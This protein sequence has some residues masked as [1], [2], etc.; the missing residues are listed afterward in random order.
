MIPS[1]V[2]AAF[3]LMPS[4]T[5]PVL[6]GDYLPLETGRQWHYRDEA[7]NQLTLTVLGT[8]I[9]ADRQT[10]ILQYEELN[11]RCYN[12]FLSW[13]DQGRLLLHARE[14]I[15][16]QVVVF[17]PPLIYLAPEVAGDVTG[18]T[19][20]YDNFRCYGCGTPGS[21][22]LVQLGA[23]TVSLPTADYTALHVFESNFINDDR[24]YAR[25]VGLVRFQYPYTTTTFE[26]VT[27]QDAAIPRTGTWGELK[28]L[29]R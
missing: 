14:S 28:V 27:W 25:N 12:T 10:H 21:N 3:W 6:A 18:T 22:Y 26:L 11:K 1:F 2:L 29:Y 9:I 15:P 24:W 16:G 8:Q 20:M 13:D 23:E 7:G 19:I 4:L 17:E 5:N